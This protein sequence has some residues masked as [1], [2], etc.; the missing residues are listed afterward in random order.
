MDK[1]LI[2]LNEPQKQAVL[3]TRG[4]VM[5]IAGAGSG[6]TRVLTRRIAHLIYNE[7]IPYENI[8]AITFTN[9]AANEMKQRIQKLLGIRTQSMWISTF[10][11]MCARILRDHIHRL[12]YDKRFQIIDDDDSVALVKTLLRRANIDVKMVNPKSLKNHIMNLKSDIAALDD[13]PE[14]IKT[15]LEIIYPGYQKYL[16]DNQLVDFEDLLVLTIALLEKHDDVRRHYHAQFAHVLIDEFQDTNNVQYR[17]IQL[18]VNEKRNVFIV[19][20]ED[21]SIYA[22]RGANIENIRKFIAA[23][24]DAKKIMLEQ[25]YRSTDTI[26]K[27]ANQ[28]IAH[29]RSRIPK[30]LFS[31][32]GEGRP[33]VFFKGY[34]YRDESE[35]IAETIRKLIREGYSYNDIAIL[36]RANATSRTFEE[37]LMQ[38]HIPYRLIGNTSYFRRKEVK[39]MVAYL[40]LMVN[41]HDDHAYARVINEP[42]RGI[43]AKSFEILHQ[44]AQR[45]AVSLYEAVSDVDNPL[46]TRPKNAFKAFNALIDTIRA[47]AESTPPSELID[48]IL[49]AS[50]Y[51][52]ALTLDEKGDVRLENILELK[53]LIEETGR[54]LG[55]Q[56]APMDLLVHVLEDIALQSREDIDYEADAVTLMTLHAA[57]GLEFRAVFIVALEQ[58]LFPLQRALEDVKDVEEERRLMY[59]GMTRAKERLYLTNARERLMY[60]NTMYNPDSAFIGEIDASLLSREGL[61][62]ATSRPTQT[63]SNHRVLQRTFE[64]S[65]PERINDLDK[66]DTVRHTAFGEGVVIRVDGPSCII[67]F[68]HPHGIKT[69]MKDHPAIEK[70][71]RS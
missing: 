10:H 64:P 62:Q 48:T 68:R 32:L 70:M 13:Y 9:K 63:A 19:G 44:F 38:K 27:A 1:L 65:K 43:G 54:K 30:A 22:F 2:E 17:L 47:Q 39:D 21:Q 24:P 20:D 36:Y 7:Q 15:Y 23:Y 29:N 6:K 55:P 4:P 46:S 3:A 51:Q 71:S 50:G 31:T 49:D 18:L 52:E 60:G 40:R 53:T 33:V 56:F 59:V 37:T 12:G 16:F 58:G 57:K 41:P 26:L 34:S 25:N 28:V 35:Y 69:L 42:R 11:A 66:G 45:E 67:A 14:P 5:A 8:L 61:N